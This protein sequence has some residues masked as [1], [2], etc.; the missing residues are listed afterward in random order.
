MGADEAGEIRGEFLLLARGPEYLSLSLVGGTKYGEGFQLFNHVADGANQPQAFRLKHYTQ[1]IDPLPALRQ[2]KFLPF[3]FV[4]PEEG[5]GLFFGQN[6]GFGFTSS[7][8]LQKPLDLAL[9][10]SGL[11]PHKPRQTRM[12]C[13]NLLKNGFWNQHFTI[14]P[15]E[16]LFASDLDEQ[17]ESSRFTY[18]NHPWSL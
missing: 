13:Q 12:N 2:H 6:N 9:I 14:K 16:N 18:H 8:S 11:Y 1:Q 3:P 10:L 4:H 17:V 5:K 7:C 15:L